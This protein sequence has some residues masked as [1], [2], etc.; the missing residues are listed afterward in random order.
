MNILIS[1]G[2]SFTQ[3]Q[4]CCPQGDSEVERKLAYPQLIATELG[5][6]CVN[7]A[8]IGQGSRS[9][10]LRLLCTDVSEYDNITVINQQTGGV[11][12]DW[13]SM[14]RDGTIHA[15]T[16]FADLDNWEGNYNQQIDFTEQFHNLLQIQTWCKA[17]NAQLINW[18]AYD[19]LTTRYQLQNYFDNFS[20]LI[21][22]S[23]WWLIDNNE[24]LTLYDYFSDNMTDE[25]K[26][27]VDNNTKF[28][29]NGDPNDFH[30]S[31]L[32]HSWIAKQLLEH[33]G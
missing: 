19:P 27:Y 32:G 4:G 6:D 30:P 5:Y 20:K 7:Y 21:D 25:Y 26:W 8:E 2:C 1:L 24:D 10:A 13:N 18:S 31:G 3:G 12:F 16:H 11:R 28:K 33:I 17:N 15:D 14:D 22:L 29:P 23:N 9:Q